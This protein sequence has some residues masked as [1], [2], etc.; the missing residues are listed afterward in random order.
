MWTAVVPLLTQLDTNRLLES[1]P[2]PSLHIVALSYT[3]PAGD[4]AEI[5]GKNSVILQRFLCILKEKVMAMPGWDTPPRIH[6]DLRGGLGKPY[7]EL[8]A[9]NIDTL[10]AAQSFAQAD[11]YSILNLTPARLGGLWRSAEAVL[12]CR[13]HGQRIMLNTDSGKS[14]RSL[15]VLSQVALGLHPDFLGA[16]AEGCNNFAQ[17][18]GEMQRALMEMEVRG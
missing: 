12:A 1:L 8:A 15:R 13:A 2:Q 10:E 4:P 9:G 18:D 5:L 16:S 11:V 3:V 17:V 6:I 14:A 7:E